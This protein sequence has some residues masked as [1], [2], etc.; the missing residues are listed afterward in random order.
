MADEKQINPLL[1]QVLELGPP[2]VFFLVYLRMKDNTYTVWGTEYSGFIAATLVLV[3]LLLAAMGVL[4]FLTGKLSRMQVFTVVMV[5]V[6]GGLTVYLND[7]KFLKIKTTIVYGIFSGLL[8]IGLLRGQS[9]LAY[10]LGELIPM[11]QDG[12]MILTRRLCAAFAGL[13][14][15]NEIIWR[16]M[17]E[18][19]WVAIETFGFPVALMVFLFW[20]MTALA[21]YMI[22]DE[23]EE[24]SGAS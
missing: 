15:V 10:I 5:V 11:E 4:W 16:T 14:I 20:Q 22:E 9:W 12:W 19:T 21:P 18:E 7:E 8:G 17:S 2:I 6:F 13:A 24:D 23:A 1:K 3:P